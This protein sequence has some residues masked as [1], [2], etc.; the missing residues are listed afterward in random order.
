MDNTGLIVTAV[1]AAGARHGGVTTGVAGTDKGA[2]GGTGGGTQEIMAD[3]N[4][5]NDGA[6][7][8]TAV[9]P[10]LTEVDAGLG[11]TGT[12]T[13]EPG[14]AAACTAAEF[15]PGGDEHVTPGS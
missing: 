8:L 13:I 9:L 4:V 2:K 14:R 11:S 12:R 5:G 15:S 1:V 7:V 10:L 3:G 6:V